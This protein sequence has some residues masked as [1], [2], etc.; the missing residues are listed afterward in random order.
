MAIVVPVWQGS[1]KCTH[2]RINL[3]QETSLS[4]ESPISQSTVHFLEYKEMPL[5]RD[6]SFIVNK[7]LGQTCSIPY[8]YLFIKKARQPAS[9][10]GVQEKNMHYMAQTQKEERD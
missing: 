6:S 10:P 7:N 5:L 4:T 1:L 8:I 3:S 9:L 2:A